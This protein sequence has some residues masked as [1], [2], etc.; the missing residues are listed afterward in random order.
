MRLPDAITLPLIAAGPLLALAFDGR[1]DVARRL[2]CGGFPVPF[3]IAHGFATAGRA[4]LGL[5]DANCSPLRSLLGLEGLPSTWSGKLRGAGRVLCAVL[6]G[7]RVEGSSTHPTFGHS[8]H[9]DSGRS[10]YGPIA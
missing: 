7:R 2:G 8:S 5:V 3:R 4:G 9:S 1:V 6:L 10:A